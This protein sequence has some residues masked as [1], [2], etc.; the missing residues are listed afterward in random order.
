LP[1][2]GRVLKK[3][4]PLGG[5]KKAYERRLLHFPGGKDGREGLGS[6]PKV[7]DA[8]CMAS[9]SCGEILYLLPGK[10]MED[11]RQNPAAVGKQKALLQWQAW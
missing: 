3:A 7:K 5:G 4:L 6:L 1:G 8:R 11:T 9:V 2:E 10:R